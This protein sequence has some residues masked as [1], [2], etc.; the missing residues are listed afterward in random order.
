MELI[1][2]GNRR[3]IMTKEVLKKIA[4]KNSHPYSESEGYEKYSVGNAQI[5]DKSEEN[6]LL[7]AYWSVLL[8]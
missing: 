6:N 8:T 7:S 2:T 3:D 5:D 4:V 1:T